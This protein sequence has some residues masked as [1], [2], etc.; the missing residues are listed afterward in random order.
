LNIFYPF[1]NEKYKTTVT[2]WAIL[3]VSFDEKVKLDKDFAEDYS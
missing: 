2:D 3:Q 1:I